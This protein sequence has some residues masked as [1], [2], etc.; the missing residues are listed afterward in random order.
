MPACKIGIC[1]ELLQAYGEGAA[2]LADGISS[3]GAQVHHHLVELGRI[4]HHRTVRKRLLLNVDGGRQ[5]G[6]QQLEHLFDDQFELHWF[7]LHIAL[8]AEGE[9]LAYEAAGPLT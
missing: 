8:A 1:F 7:W 4:G 5:R 9:N 2:L 3:I 6:A